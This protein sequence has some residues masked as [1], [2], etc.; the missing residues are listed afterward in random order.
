VSTNHL[1]TRTSS[2]NPIGSGKVESDDRIS[3]NSKAYGYSADVY[4]RLA[5]HP[6]AASAADHEH[7]T[8]GVS[9][10]TQAALRQSA[11]RLADE[12]TRLHKED[13]STAQQKWADMHPQIWKQTGVIHAP[14]EDLTQVLIPGRSAISPFQVNPHLLQGI[15][16]CMATP[17]HKGKK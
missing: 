4:R 3:T 11:V 10:Q 9:P 12:A 7:L 8:Q 1:G 14:S 2:V 6:A 15:S 5:W 17:N 16:A 13:P